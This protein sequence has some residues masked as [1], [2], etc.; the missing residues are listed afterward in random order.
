MHSLGVSDKTES[1]PEWP[2][3]LC[4]DSPFQSLEWA[5]IAEARGRA[6]RYHWLLAQMLGFT[7]ATPMST[8]R[9]EMH[10]F[11]CCSDCFNKRSESSHGDL[12]ETLSA[13]CLPPEWTNSFL[14][15]ALLSTSVYLNSPLSY[16]WPLPCDFWVT[17]IASAP[18]VFC[19]TQ[20]GHGEL[21]S[22]IAFTWE[23]N[24]LLGLGIL[25][26]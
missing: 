26:M 8:L 1:E 22:L 2:W 6:H 20:N 12:E 24:F 18:S 7:V 21:F 17:H 15:S 25:T 4:S 3:I 19:G 5:V 14:L 9:S 23:L 10:I 11:A 16:R 13:T